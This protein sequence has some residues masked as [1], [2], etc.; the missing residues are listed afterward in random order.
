MGPI[1]PIP[2]GK[3]AVKICRWVIIDLPKLDHIAE[4]LGI[5][6]KLLGIDDE[7]AKGSVEI[8]I[9][10]PNTRRRSKRK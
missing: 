4:L 3:V 8:T 6:E 7:T 5:D 1:P 9:I 2:P 10:A